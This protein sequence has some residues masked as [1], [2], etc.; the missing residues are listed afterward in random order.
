MELKSIDYDV[1]FDR[2]CSVL[3]E[4]EED[5]LEGIADKIVNEL[6]YKAEISVDRIF[7]FA[8]R[9]G[10]SIDYLLGRSEVYSV[11]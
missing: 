6:V 5:D 8:E 2:V 9:Y 10:C 4:N 3:R 11:I 1:I 7:D